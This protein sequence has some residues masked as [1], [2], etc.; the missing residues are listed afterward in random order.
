MAVDSQMLKGILDGCILKIIS[1]GEIYSAQIVEYMKSVG[2]IDFSEGTLYPLLLRL[3]REGCFEIR[4]E[5][6]S[7]GPARKFYKLSLN[8]IKQLELFLSKWNDFLTLVS[9][10]L[11]DKNE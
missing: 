7:L 9:K 1:K 3:E 5:S 2:F 10:I 6:N 8:G 11:E 4:K